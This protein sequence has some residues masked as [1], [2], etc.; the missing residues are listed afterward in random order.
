[1]PILLTILAI[2]GTA[3]MIWV[4]GGILMHGLEAYG[5]S[6][7]AHA[8]HAMAEAAA[9]RV[10]FAAGLVAW[11]VT[12]TVSGVIGLVAGPV[13]PVAAAR[14]TEGRDREPPGPARS[15]LRECRGA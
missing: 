7:P 10:P 15:S 13:R 11:L 12:A 6:A 3:A 5:L 1:M 9:A 4:G 8:A 2:I 14:L